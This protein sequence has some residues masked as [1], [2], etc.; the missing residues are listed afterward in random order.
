MVLII[1]K[2]LHERNEN[3]DKYFESIGKYKKLDEYLLKKSLRQL[4][5]HFCHEMKYNYEFDDFFFKL[6]RTGVPYLARKMIGLSHPTMEISQEGEKWTIKNISLI[7]TQE[8]SF[9]LGKE[10]E[11]VMPAGDKLQV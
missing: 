3:I 10:Y 2:Y 6:Q 5:S 7:N 9:Y 1:G 11:E 4:E 8:V